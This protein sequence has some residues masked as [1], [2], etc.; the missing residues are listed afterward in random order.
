MEKGRQ[1]PINIRPFLENLTCRGQGIEAVCA[2]RPEG[3]VRVD[4]L[5]RWLGLGPE[6]LAESVRRVAVQWVSNTNNLQG[7]HQ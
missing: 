6:D 4:E 2:F 3:T 7:V 1:R 5:M